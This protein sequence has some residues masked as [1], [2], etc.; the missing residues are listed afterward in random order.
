MDTHDVSDVPQYVQLLSKQRKNL[1]DAQSRKGQRPQAR[2]SREEIMMKFMFSVMMKQAGPNLQYN[3]RSS[4][5]PPAYPPCI[6][7]FS[8]LKKI[9]IKDLLLETHHRGTYLLVRSTTPPDKMNAIM[10]IVED[11]LKDVV[12]LQLYYQEG[13]NDCAIEDI[14]GEGMILIVREPY[15]KLMSDG[16]HGV[17]VDHLSD[18]IYLPVYDERVP[19]CWQT[20]TAEFITSADAWKTKGN[21]HFKK[22]KYRTAIEC[23]TKALDCSPA[24]EEAQTIKLNR[25]LA[26]LKEKQFE[27]ALADLESLQSPQH[28]TE[29]AL[30][31][32]TLSLYNL[33]RYREC[34][35]VLKTLRLKYP[36]NEAAK[37]K[38]SQTIHRLT[39][40]ESG[41]YNFKQL[42]AEAAK[43]RPPH[44]DHSTYVGPVS[45]RKSNGRGR[46][47]FTT[48]A[49]KA[50]ELLLCEKAFA[51]AF[52]DTEKAG[53]LEN[54][55]ILVN[56]ETSSMTVGAQSELINLI[57]QKLYR[58]PSLATVITSLHHGS[59]TPV[60]VSEVDGTPV[61]DTFLVE[62]IINLNCF[63]CPL[64]SR[65]SHLRTMD[66]KAEQKVIAN[67][68]LFHSC[69]IWPM[70]SYINHCCYSNAR[71]AFIGDMMIVRATRDLAPDTEITFWYHM[72]DPIRY[73][74][75][76]KK[77]RHWDFK[78]DCI[79]CQDD[80]TTKKSVW[81]KR[82][83]LRADA[84][85]YLN[86][87]K[88]S[89]AARIETILVAITATYPRPA[90]EA[91]RLCVWDVQLALAKMYLDH[92][93]TV[94]AVEVGLR[95]L[96]S[97]GY[98]IDG[99]RLPRTVGTPMAV[100]QWG[101][102]EDR[103]IEC[104]MLLSRAYSLVAPD[105]ESQATGYARTSY[106][107][108]VGEDESFD[109]TYGRIFRQP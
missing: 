36:D 39:E 40:Q 99:G 72:P 77:F 19:N 44:L 22:S 10:T 25:S 18:V 17:R 96:E 86:S 88:K 7:P 106:K 32:K 102:M 109:E 37:D 63:G 3:M 4:F 94:K 51:H 74:E 8:D 35:E 80:E 67:E 87:G 14:A 84:Q 53:G 82:K 56:S 55:T 83:S 46:G 79:I 45:I 73:E 57:V 21:D 108:C 11:E 15:F 66:D 26:F 61:V 28:A 75:R 103:L 68:K 50:G 59:Y 52:V 85:K 20:K 78:C 34:C 12:M 64:S 90:S 23:Y 105:L 100:K 69:G 27:A 93:Q 65:E 81:Q 71:R 1:Q 97:L 31:R 104:W 107:I 92:Q 2:R 76:Q 29:K 9:M 13:D 101:L 89:D 95:S 38:F 49:V 41:R 91:P 54:V 48:K 58:N 60:N 42:R 62:R 16:E 24:A 98:V 33:G 43:L 30:Y 6:S 47:L 70:A 5:V